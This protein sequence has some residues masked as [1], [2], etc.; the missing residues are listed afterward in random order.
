MPL[1]LQV[2]S[3]IQ[4]RRGSG[5]RMQG[6]RSP[7]PPP[8]QG[9][10]FFVVAFNSLMVYHFQKIGL[11]WLCFGWDKNC[12][13][14]KKNAKNAKYNFNFVA[15]FRDFKPRR[16]HRAQIPV[17]R[18][19]L[20]QYSELICFVALSE[21]VSRMLSQRWMEYVTHDG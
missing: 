17:Y 18:A 8:P 16:M 14:H 20:F 9:E 12:R 5:G 6:M 7:P 3:I 13:Q 2:T 10:A 19:V 11:I 1:V 21:T 4:D 15:K